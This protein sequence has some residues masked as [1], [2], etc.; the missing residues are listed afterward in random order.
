MNRNHKS[1]DLCAERVRIVRKELDL[2]QAAFGELV[3]CEPNYISMIERGERPVSHNMAR[4]ISASA[5]YPTRVDWVMGET[6]E[7]NEREAA[8]W[9][10]DKQKRDHA[11]YYASV[12]VLE[13]AAQR[14]GLSFHTFID[15]QIDNE[16]ILQYCSSV[17][18]PA[19]A[20]YMAFS[21]HSAGNELDEKLECASLYKIQKRLERYAEF[22]I[23]EAIEEGDTEDGER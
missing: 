23:R 21:L 16:S 3:G 10:L 9:R 4:K 19:R 7:R 18:E 5:K 20:K 11:S 8:E 6:D 2:T 15:P 22:L 12:L 14:M 17:L 1:N 13:D